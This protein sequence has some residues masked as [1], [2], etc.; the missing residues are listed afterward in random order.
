MLFI[1]ILVLFHRKKL[2]FVSIP[3]QKKSSITVCNGFYLHTRFEVKVTII[4]ASLKKVDSGKTLFF[5]VPQRSASNYT[6]DSCQLV[7]T[8][9][10]LI[11]HSVYFLKSE[12]Q[13]SLSRPNALCIGREHDVRG[14]TSSSD[15]GL[16][17]WSAWPL[18]WQNKLQCRKCPLHAGQRD[19][20]LEWPL[21]NISCHSFVFST[22]SVHLS[23]VIPARDYCILY[24]G[25]RIIAHIAWPQLF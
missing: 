18:F 7:R 17:H 25:I 16:T 20:A 13:Y 1:S 12:W 5:H 10:L 24:S 8:G 23:F 4:S 21:V 3:V 11:M 14:C 2:R 9:T 22:I 6:T 15:D 19:R